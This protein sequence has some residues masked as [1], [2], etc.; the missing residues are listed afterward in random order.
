MQNTLSDRTVTDSE[1]IYVNVG[2]RLMLHH[3]RK[4]YKN[5]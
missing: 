1:Y 2:L 4:K 5:S 3:I